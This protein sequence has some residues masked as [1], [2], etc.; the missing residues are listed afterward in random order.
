MSDIRVG[1]TQRVITISHDRACDALEHTYQDFLVAQGIDFVPVPNFLENPTQ[2]L[3]HQH[4]THVVLSGGGDVHAGKHTSA[5]EKRLYPREA[6]EAAAITYALKEKLPVLGICRGAQVLN[7][8]FDGALKTLKD[9]KHVATHHKVT[10]VDPALA[11]T[12]K[13]SEAVV[14]SY[15]AHGIPRTQLAKPLVPFAVATDDSIEGFYHRSAPVVGIMWHPERTTPTTKIDRMLIA[16]FVDRKGYW[17][18]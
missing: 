13:K 2:F 1:I 11:K 6:T 16:E 4:I 3:K 12:L 9:V 5:R 14:N 17:Q 18:V 10:I 7:V 15:H 8:H